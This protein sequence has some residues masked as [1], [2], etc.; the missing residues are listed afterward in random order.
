MAT[1]ND[2]VPGTEIDRPSATPSDG[3]A[4]AIL[5]AC[6]RALRDA[7]VPD[8]IIEEYTTEAKSGDYDELIRTS[9]KYCEIDV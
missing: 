9:M 5:G 7:G 6:R 3:N 1:T 4:F 8:K 2:Y